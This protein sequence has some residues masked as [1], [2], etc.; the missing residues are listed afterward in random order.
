MLRD[1][2]VNNPFGLMLTLQ[3]FLYHIPT[4]RGDEAVKSLIRS[5]LRRLWPSQQVWPDNFLELALSFTRLLHG[6]RELRWQE[7]LERIG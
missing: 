7:V 2:K 1:M 3:P 5:E 6:L 4:T